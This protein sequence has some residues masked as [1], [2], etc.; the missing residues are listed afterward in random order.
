MHRP[1]FSE[2]RYKYD[3]VLQVMASFGV[4]LYTREE[5][6]FLNMRKTKIL[7]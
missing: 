6:S 2:T 3:Y 1:A 4:S 7:S 5:F